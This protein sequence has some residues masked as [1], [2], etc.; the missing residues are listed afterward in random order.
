MKIIEFLVISMEVMNPTISLD[1]NKKKQILKF[2]NRITQILKFL[3][4][5]ARLIKF[6]KIV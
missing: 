1:N 6:I 5:Q 2:H 4:F 3:A